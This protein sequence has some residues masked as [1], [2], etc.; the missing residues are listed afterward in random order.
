[1]RPAHGVGNELRQWLL[2]VL[3][4]RARLLRHVLPRRHLRLVVHGTLRTRCVLQAQLAD[5]HGE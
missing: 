5:Q 4:G 2:R 1:M 3:A